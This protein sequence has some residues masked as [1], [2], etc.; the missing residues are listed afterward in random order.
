MA[1][2]D[3]NTL[4]GFF[5]TGDNPTEGQ[6]ANLIDSFIAFSGENTGSLNLLGDT[7]I[8]G[9]ITSSG[10]RV[11]GNI[12]ITGTVDTGQGATEVYLMNQNIQTSDN[13]TFA[14]ITAGGN[15]EF[16]N[17]ISDTHIFTG[18]VTSS[19]NISSSQFIIANQFVGDGKLITGITSSLINR[20]LYFANFF[21][22]LI[23]Q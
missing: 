22:P 20:I 21:P 18:H 8:D 17:N 5:E 23:A 19:N 9:N 1:Q 2:K 4:K 7:N 6:Y 16:G 15:T 11:V 12:V 3:R 14:D 13:V 10:L